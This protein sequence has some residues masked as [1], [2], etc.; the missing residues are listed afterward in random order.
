MEVIH[1]IITLWTY[2]LQMEL[3]GIYMHKQAY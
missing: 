1:K 2:Q 3:T